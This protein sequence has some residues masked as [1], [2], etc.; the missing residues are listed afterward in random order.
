MVN[1]LKTKP[2][3][4]DSILMGNE[5]L[6]GI[7]NMIW[8]CQIMTRK[9]Y[10]TVVI[11]RS[12]CQPPHHEVH[13]SVI[14]AVKRIARVEIRH[15]IIVHADLVMS[16]STMKVRLKPPWPKPMPQGQLTHKR[17]SL[18]RIGCLGLNSRLT[19]YQGEGFGSVQSKQCSSGG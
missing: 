6:H 13:I 19:L 16:R 18:K 11:H 4:R 2:F 1:Y 10:G 14:R 15:H 9:N 8:W 12:D 7:I 3:Y 17:G 5:E